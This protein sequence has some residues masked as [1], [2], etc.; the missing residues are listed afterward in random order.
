M[1][2]QAAGPVTLT[3]PLGQVRVFDGSHGLYSQCTVT[4][5]RLP[6]LCWTNQTYL[7]LLWG[8]PCLAVV[9]ALPAARGHRTLSAKQG[10]E[11]HHLAAAFYTHITSHPATLHASEHQ[12]TP[13]RLS[14]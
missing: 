4:A 13:L 11:L 6:V 9:V 5:L 12:L 2:D 3:A 1:T 8:W 7:L 10:F 14:V